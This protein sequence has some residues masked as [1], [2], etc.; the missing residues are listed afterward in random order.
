MRLRKVRR[1]PGINS[2]I[3]IIDESNLD[4]LMNCIPEKYSVTIMYMRGVIPLIIN[5]SF[6]KLIHRILQFK[7]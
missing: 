3:L 4:Y 6:F 5:G 7:D 1:I 2:D